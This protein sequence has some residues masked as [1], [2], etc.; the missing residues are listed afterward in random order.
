MNYFPEYFQ[1][2]LTKAEKF[3]QLGKE[4][5]DDT[6]FALGYQMGN[7]F[8][9]A[10]SSSPTQQDTHPLLSSNHNTVKNSKKTAFQFTNKELLKMPKDL[11]KL[12]NSGKIK[13]HRRQRENGTYEIRCTYNKT[14]ITGSGKTISAAKERFLEN[15]IAKFSHSGI[16]SKKFTYFNDFAELWFETVKKPT[17]KPNTY[18]S[19]LSTYQVHIKPYFENIK[20][21]DATPL[22]IQ[23][24]FNSLFQKGITRGSDLT[25]LLLTQ[26]FNAACSE[27]LIESNPMQYVRVLKYEA[28]KGKALSYQEESDLLNQLLDPIDRLAIGLLLY[29]GIRRGE[30][31]SLY[32][33]DGFVVVKNSKRKLNQRD[34]FRKIP[35]T[36]ML[37]PYLIGITEQKLYTAT[38][39]AP[40]TLDNH[41]KSKSP[42]HHLHELRHTFITRCQE[43]GVPRE[44]VSVWAGHA[45]DRTMTSL[46]YTH[47]SHEFM[48]EQ[49]QKVNYTAKL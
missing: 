19:E 10:N 36:P 8:A 14:P 12:I 39:I 9:E 13:M 6:I 44:V 38:H 34:S 28:Q 37:S 35:I 20:L 15:L 33:K 29:T 32:I 1:K 2:V 49:A 5:Y 3:M 47:F 23:P 18:K 17:V 43:C 42:N 25:K 40:S 11:R 22:F 46:V 21:K 31:P 27:N 7:A 41:F 26:I 24:L 30:L 48:Q 4:L 16:I 45:A